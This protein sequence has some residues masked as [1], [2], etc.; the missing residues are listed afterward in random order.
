MW[1]QLLTVRNPARSVKSAGGAPRS[2]VLG[3]ITLLGWLVACAHPQRTIP[4]E[5]G[6]PPVTDSGSVAAVELE[7]GERITF[8]RYTGLYDTE[9]K[10]FI[11]QA[12]DSSIVSAPQSEVRWVLVAMT[13]DVPPRISKFDKAA[14]F[15]FARDKHSRKAKRLHTCSWKTRGPGGCPGFWITEFSILSPIAAEFENE[16]KAFGTFQ[17]GYLKTLDN[18]WGVGGELYFATGRNWR[19]GPRLR[20]RRWLN[21]D[22]AVDVAAGLTYDIDDRSHLRESKIGYSNI[23]SLNYQETISVGLGYDVFPTGNDQMRRALCG[24]VTVGG[25]YG[26]M[27]WGSVFVVLALYLISSPQSM[28][29]D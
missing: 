12:I 4:V 7:S 10:R 29:W 1:Q 15:R 16:R 18:N 5:T 6:P 28:S 11:G 26:R 3:M 21:D 27:A 8:H 20:V 9:N 13:R 22:F 2:H 14:F 23:V 24:G 19:I 25:K 17:C